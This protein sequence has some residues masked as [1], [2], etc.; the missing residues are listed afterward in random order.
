MIRRSTPLCRTRN[1][2]SWITPGSMGESRIPSAETCWQSRTIGPTICSRNSPTLAACPPTGAA[3]AAGTRFRKHLPRVRIRSSRQDIHNPFWIRFWISVTAM[4]P[5]QDRAR[6]SL[7][8]ALHRVPAPATATHG[9]SSLS[10]TPAGH[11]QRPSHPSPP[12]Q[13]RCLACHGARFV[14][15]PCLPDCWPTRFSSLTGLQPK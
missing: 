6:R 9:L 15:P 13:A 11:S 4:A 3:K 2:E 12:R 14:S 7:S 1:K 5:L 8:L 10:L